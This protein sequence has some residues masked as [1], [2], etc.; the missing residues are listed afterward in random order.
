[1][2]RARVAVM[3][4]VSHQL[5]VTDTARQY[6]YSRRQLH[7]LLARYRTDGLNAVEPRSRRPSYTRSGTREDHRP[8]S[9]RHAGRMRHLGIGIEHAGKRGIAVADDHTITVIHLDTGEVIASNDIQPDKAY[10]RNTQKAPPAD[11]RGLPRDSCRD[12]S[13]GGG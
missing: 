4:V 7:R 6:G 2:S 5:S 13:H 11:G 1:M 3:K 8:M 10:W 9:F 12:S